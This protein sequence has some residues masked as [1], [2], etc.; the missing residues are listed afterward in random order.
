MASLLVGVGQLSQL[1][2]LWLLPTDDL[3]LELCM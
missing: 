2:K 3:W 1:A